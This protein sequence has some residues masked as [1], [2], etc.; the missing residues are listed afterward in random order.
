MRNV[1]SNGENHF[2]VV[3][4]FDVNAAPPASFPIHFGPYTY[5]YCIR[6]GSFRGARSAFL[7]SIM[8]ILCFMY[9]RCT[10]VYNALHK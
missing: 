3:Y 4:N 5:R 7:C 9:F 8:R 6:F 10:Y 1:I 2:I